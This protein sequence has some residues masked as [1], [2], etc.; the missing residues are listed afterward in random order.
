MLLVIL[1]EK[2]ADLDKYKYSG[3][4]MEFDSSSNF[5]FKMEAWESSALLPKDLIRS[6]KISAL[7]KMTFSDSIQLKMIKT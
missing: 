4:G 2:N 7:T 3:Y 6:T 1:T 5:C